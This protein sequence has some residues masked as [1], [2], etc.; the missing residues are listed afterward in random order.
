MRLFT[1]LCTTIIKYT[2]MREIYKSLESL[3]DIKEPYKSLLVILQDMY[4]AGPDKSA[5]LPEELPL[6]LAINAAQAIYENVKQNLTTYVPILR[7]ETKA[8][9]KANTNRELSINNFHV[10]TYRELACILGCTY[11]AMVCDEEFDDHQLENIEKIISNFISDKGLPYFNVFKKAADEIKQKD[12][13]SQLLCENSITKTNHQKELEQKDKEIK[14]LKAIIKEYTGEEIIKGK[15]Y[16]TINQ[17]AIAVYFML[18]S[19]NIRIL[20]NQS[21]WANIISKIARRN[22]QNLRDAFG[23]INKDIETL[24]KD[25]AKIVANAFDDVAPTLANKIRAN[26]KIVATITEDSPN[27][28][29]SV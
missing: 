20:D 17:I 12:Q 7:E 23:Q 14:Q 22:I 28:N 13:G 3:K 24:R 9:F 16:F 8:I 11:Y 2:I 1:Y 15:P 27:N 4:V 29:N 26:A 5:P 21:G 19:V 25:D 10:P 6:N 18:D